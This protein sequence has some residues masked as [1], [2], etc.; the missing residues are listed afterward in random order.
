[1]INAAQAG[2]LPASV[3]IVHNSPLTWLWQIGFSMANDLAKFLVY[4]AHLSDGNLVTD[5][6]SIGKM[7]S[8]T[9]QDPPDAPPA[10]GLNQH[11]TFEGVFSFSTRGC[12]SINHF[13]NQATQA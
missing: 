8:L 13:L 10:G 1:M 6:L 5:L 7:T 9:G 2:K 12:T 3:S 4:M 11:G